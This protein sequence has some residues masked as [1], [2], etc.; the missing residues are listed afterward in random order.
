MKTSGSEEVNV[1]LKILCAAE[2][3]HQVLAPSFM[4]GGRYYNVNLITLVGVRV[5]ET[6]E[7]NFAEGLHEKNTVPAWNLYTNCTNSA[8]ALGPRKTTEN[9]YR[10]EK[11]LNLT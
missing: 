3:I 8:F 11:I 5:D 10:L 9:F 4:F 1:M 7:V 2:E 6:F